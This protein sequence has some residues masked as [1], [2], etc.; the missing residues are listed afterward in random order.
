MGHGEIQLADC[1]GQ[2]ADVRF[3]MGNGGWGIL[4]CRL[5]I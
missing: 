2:Q 3:E 1:S 5:R 4:D